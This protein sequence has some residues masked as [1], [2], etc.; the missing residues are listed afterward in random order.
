[1]DDVRDLIL[2]RV[3]LGDGAPVF[4]LAPA[5][6]ALDWVEAQASHTEQSDDPHVTEVR[7]RGLPPLYRRDPHSVPEAAVPRPEFVQLLFSCADFCSQIAFRGV[8][9]LTRRVRGRASSRICFGRGGVLGSGL[10]VEPRFPR[11][12]PVTEVFG[13]YGRVRGIRVQRCARPVDEDRYGPVSP[14]QLG[15]PVLE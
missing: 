12:R 15:Q 3:E 2:L 1:M 14:G 4:E 9:H 10:Y 6:T 13:P 7:I 8:V 11:Q 5:P